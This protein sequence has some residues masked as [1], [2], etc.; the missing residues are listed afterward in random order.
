MTPKQSVLK[1]HPH[2]FAMKR[3][4]GV[5]VYEKQAFG[6]ELGIGL[7]RTGAWRDAAAKVRAASTRAEDR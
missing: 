2:A 7:T 3:P 6:R 4:F 1:K 5:V